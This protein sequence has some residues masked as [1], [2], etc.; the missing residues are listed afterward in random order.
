M[1]ITQKKRGC[2]APH[3]EPRSH[4]EINSL[5]KHSEPPHGLASAIVRMDRFK[6]LEARFH[7]LGWALSP[8][9]G[10]ATLAVHRKWAIHQICQT[11]GDAA[12][13][14]RRIGG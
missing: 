13:L 9:C 8:L 12:Q 1:R 2:G 10:E 6:E 14:L 7:A 11:Y 3:T 5:R 4:H